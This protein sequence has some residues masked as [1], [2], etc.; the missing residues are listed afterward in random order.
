MTVPHHCPW[1][2]AFTGYGTPYP[3]EQ[4]QLCGKCVQILVLQNFT[5]V[6]QE[7]IRSLRAESLPKD[8][9][10]ARLHSSPPAVAASPMTTAGVSFQGAG[11]SAEELRCS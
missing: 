10:S 2:K 11:Q 3:P 9:T 8:P 1:C 7:H 5:R 6:H 4:M